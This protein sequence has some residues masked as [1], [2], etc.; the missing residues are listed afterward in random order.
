M[1][2]DIVTLFPRIFMGPFDES[3]IGR[4]RERGQAEIGFVNPR[5]F[6]LDRRGSVDDTPFGGGAGMVLRPDVLFAAVES[7]RR[8]DS[9]VVLMSPQ[10]EKFHQK[11]AEELALFPHLIVI[12]GHYEGVDERIRQGLVD[13]EFSIGDYVLTN[14][15]LAAM[16]IA[17]AVIRLLPGVL[18]DSTSAD[19]D[20]FARSGGIEYPQYTKPVEFRGMRPPDLLLSG[21]HVEIKKWRREQSLLRTTARRPDIFTSV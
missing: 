17:D 4:A 10:G 16:V 12:C 6:A 11:T 7:V 2:I 3:I 13:R 18:G 5:D 19:N 1:R 14:G 20:S 21:N 8:S 9:L 15:G